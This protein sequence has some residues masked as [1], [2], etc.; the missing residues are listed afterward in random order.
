MATKKSKTST[1]STK[2]KSTK[3]GTAEKSVKKSEIEAPKTNTVEETK[4]A[5]AKKSCFCGFF[6]KKYEEKESILTIFK[7]HKFY[8]ALLG[9]VIGTMLIA[10]LLFALSLMGIANVAM[11]TFAVIAVLVAVYAF[12]GACLNPI[13]TVGMMAT[14]RM[15]VI[16]GIMYI[17]AEILGAWL[18]WLIFNGFHLAGGETAYDVPTMS[19]VAEGGFWMVAMVELLGAAIIG[20]FFSRAIEYKRSTFTFAAVIAGGMAL[21]VLIGYVVSAAFLGINSN[22]IFNPAVALMMQIF[23]TAGE[24]FGEIF[25]GVCQALSIYAL[26][27]MIGGVIGFYLSDFAK[28]LSED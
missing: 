1:K 18:G 6:A 27:P 7:S 20:F 10:L 23:P 19:A 26:I 9:E 25:G 8:G 3:G 16:R 21:A 28:K 13:V 5:N 24:N 22:F 2:A 4:N 12:S 14:R 15:S 11:Y 17:I